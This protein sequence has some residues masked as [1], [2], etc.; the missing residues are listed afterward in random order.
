MKTDAKFFDQVQE[1]PLQAKFKKEKGKDKGIYYVYYQNKKIAKR[2]V[3]LITN[4]KCVEYING[5]TLDLRETN[6]KEIGQVKKIIQDNDK[7]ID[8]QY[9]YFNIRIQ[10]LPKNIWLLGKAAGTIFKR[11]GQTTQTVSVTDR[12]KNS[13]KHTKTFSIEE[14]KS[15]EA[16][17]NA[18]IKWKIETSYKLGLT[19]NLIRIL[20]DEKTIEVKLRDNKTTKLDRCFIPLIQQVFLSYTI[21]DKKIY[22]NI[23]KNNKKLHE[24]LM[25]SS[26]VEHINY[27]TLDNHLCNLKL[28][29]DTLDNI[30]VIN[31]ISLIENESDNE[32]DN[33]N[34][35]NL[36]NNINDKTIDYTSLYLNNMIFDYDSYLSEIKD[37][38][39]DIDKY[40]KEMFN[41]YLKINLD[42]ITNLSIE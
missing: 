33:K 23:T 39:V 27:D 36:I 15:D 16:A 29:N 28:V 21:V 4:Y 7:I 31:D 13:I 19:A 22:C 8:N 34:D 10:N 37:L 41:E 32:C 25:G 40:K 2:F 11:T 20:D 24:L 38:D 5:D 42:K 30:E 17:Y 12:N 14:Y 3:S 18:A 9:K 35:D 26:M 1:Y 6:L